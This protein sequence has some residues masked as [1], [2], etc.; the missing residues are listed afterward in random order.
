MFG[1]RRKVLE[2]EHVAQNMLNSE[3]LRIYI[4]NALRNFSLL[5]VQTESVNT[6]KPQ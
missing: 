6:S 4:P 5:C 1:V 3:H 2:D